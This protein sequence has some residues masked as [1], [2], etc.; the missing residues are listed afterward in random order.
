MGL[1]LDDRDRARYV[2]LECGFADDGGRRSEEDPR[3]R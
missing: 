2:C 3:T 1:A